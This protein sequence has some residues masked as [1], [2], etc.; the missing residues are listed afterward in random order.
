MLWYVSHG[1][2]IT[3]Y[4]LCDIFRHSEINVA[5]VLIPLEVDATL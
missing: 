3:S 1:M 5:F 4:L 2:H